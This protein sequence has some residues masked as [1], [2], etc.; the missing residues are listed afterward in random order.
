[1]QTYASQAM[2]FSVTSIHAWRFPFSHA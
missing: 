1:M 2:L